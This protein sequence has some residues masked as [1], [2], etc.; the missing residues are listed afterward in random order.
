[1]LYQIEVCYL[2]IAKNYVV[3]IYDDA[4]LLN[5]VYLSFDLFKVNMIINTGERELVFVEKI[6]KLLSRRTPL[7]L[8]Q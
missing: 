1:M 3:A 8:W 5:W 2:L 7:L 4:M 6:L